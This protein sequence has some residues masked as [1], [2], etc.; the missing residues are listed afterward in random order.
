MGVSPP[1]PTRVEGGGILDPPAPCRAHAFQHRNRTEAGPSLH[2]DATEREARRIVELGLRRGHP[3]APTRQEVQLVGPGLLRRDAEAAGPAAE[4]RG[5]LHREIPRP[6]LGQPQAQIDVLELVDVARIETLRRNHVCRPEHHR[7]AA[8]RGRPQLSRASGVGA[9]K[10]LQEIGGEEVGGEPDLPGRIHRGLGGEDE[11]LHAKH[12]GIRQ[13][14]DEDAQPSLPHRHLGIEEE[15]VF[16]GAFQESQRAIAR[17][18]VAARQAPVHDVRVARPPPEER[19]CLPEPGSVIHK[20]DLQIVD[21]GAIQQRLHGL[22]RGVEVASAGH[23]DREPSGHPQLALFRLPV[24]HGLCENDPPPVGGFGDCHPI[25]APHVM[26]VVAADEG[27]QDGRRDGVDPEDEIVIDPPF[28]G[29]VKSTHLPRELGAHHEHVEVDVVEVVHGAPVALEGTIGGRSGAPVPDLLAR[30]CGAQIV[31]FHGAHHEFEVVLAPLVVRIEKGEVLAAGLL[32]PG[33]A[34]RTHPLGPGNAHRDAGVGPGAL[35]QVLKA[36]IG[37][38]I[39]NQMQLPVRVA[40]CQHGIDCRAH[41]VAAIPHRH[42]DGHQRRAGKR[43]G[44]QLP[45]E[46]LLRVLVPLRALPRCRDPLLVLQRPDSR[47][48]GIHV[49]AGGTPRERGV[50][51]HRQQGVRPKS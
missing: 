1:I 23:H 2:R 9:G 42:D 7:G 28:E 4:H 26:G 48:E 21:V 35:A 34:C 43:L 49:G 36:A 44:A 3:S 47:G 27:H 32:H 17:V 40:L 6:R 8:Q 51:G 50:C 18:V 16:S 46:C 10:I 15:H 24:L 14:I 45:L 37:G 38:V 33:V 11:W 5:G 29:V 12:L 22:V 30:V 41:H 20:D 31:A 39:V 19:R 25:R 13:P